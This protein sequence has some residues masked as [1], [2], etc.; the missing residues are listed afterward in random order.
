MTKIKPLTLVQLEY[1]ISLETHRHFA[2]AAEK[3][4]VTQPTLSMQI[5]KLEDSLGVIIFDRKKHPIEPTPIG[6]KII[7]QARNILNESKKITELIDDEKHEIHG[8]IN[9][10]I[11]PTLAPYLVP[12]F[13][14]SLIEKYP[15]LN[16][17]ISELVTNDLVKSIKN[18][19]IDIGLLVTPLNEEN[20]IEKPMFYE[21]FQAYTSH[22]HKI[23]KENTIEPNN[24]ATDGLWLLNE[25]HCFRNQSLNICNIKNPSNHNGRINYE[26]GSLEGLK[27]MVDRHGGFTLLPELN[28]LGLSKDDK[29]KLRSFKEPV[30]TREVSLVVKKSYPKSKLIQAVFNEII[31]NLPPIMASRKNAKIIKWK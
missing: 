17:N 14:S 23:F 9:I 13:V 7:E 3:C 26:S 15:K 1:I 11:I 8:Q 19:Q 6:V 18:D 4:F 22:H 25:G 20:F 28:A 21:A 10:G 12:L 29:S 30:P 27:R 24:L 16:L 31:D 5:Q 2:L